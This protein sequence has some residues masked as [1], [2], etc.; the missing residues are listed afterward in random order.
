MKTPYVLKE[1]GC[2]PIQFLDHKVAFKTFCK[3]IQAGR[4]AILVR[5]KR[6]IYE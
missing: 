2:K 3:V 1:Q 6:T 4:K 5:T